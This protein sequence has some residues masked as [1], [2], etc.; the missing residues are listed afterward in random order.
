MEEGDTHRLEE[1]Q[2]TGQE[3][4]DHSATHSMVDLKHLKPAGLPV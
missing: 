2:A 4:G 1:S 3:A